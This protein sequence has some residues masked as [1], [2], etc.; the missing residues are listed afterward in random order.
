MKDF[1][2]YNKQS[3]DLMDYYEE[4]DELRNREVRKARRLVKDTLGDEQVEYR[5]WSIFEH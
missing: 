4:Q 1:D 5:D 3:D 2:Y